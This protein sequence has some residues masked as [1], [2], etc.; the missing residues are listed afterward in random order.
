MNLKLIAITIAAIGY[1][2]PALA[3]APSGVYIKNIRY[4]GTGCPAYTVSKNLSPDAKAFTLHI[5]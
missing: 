4:N 1:Q 5:Q 3:S 2:L